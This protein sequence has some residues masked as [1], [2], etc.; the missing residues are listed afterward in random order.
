M[1]LTNYIDVSKIYK[2]Y[3]KNTY[4]FF[5]ELFEQHI[6]P[7]FNDEEVM[8]CVTDFIHSLCQNKYKFSIF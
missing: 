3:I 4:P 1:G 6:E 2:F 5:F 8:L 7:F